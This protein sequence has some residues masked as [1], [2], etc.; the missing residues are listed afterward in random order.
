MATISLNGGTAKSGV[1]MNMTRN[2][3]MLDAGMFGRARLCGD[4]PI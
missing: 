1:P 4:R 3:S 2:R